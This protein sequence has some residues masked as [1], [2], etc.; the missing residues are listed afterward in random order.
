[1][2]QNRR[3]SAVATTLVALAV[4]I[5]PGFSQDASDSWGER[6]ATT[7]GALIPK[8][9]PALVSEMPWDVPYD[10]W[11]EL[12]WGC[13]LGCSLYTQAKAAREWKF[14]DAA[15][16]AEVEKAETDPNQAE[17]LGVLTRSARS[18]RIVIHANEVATTTWGVERPA[19]AAGTIKGFRAYRFAFSD[20]SYAPTSEGVRLAV[21]LG[22][23]GF[24]NPR[25][26]PKASKGEFRTIVV[27]AAVQS[28][29][30]RVKQDEALAR[31]MLEQVDFAALA[32]LL[33]TPAQD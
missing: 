5:T 29:P 21:A 33:K 20:E 7:L 32:A 27:S 12:G 6:A 17:R 8:P 24:T 15:L 23:D 19:T 28:T 1:M 25:A 22:P 11:P 10:H 9:D 16:V 26:D 4:G 18:L 14:A 31:K 13:P 3:T 2:G 30:A